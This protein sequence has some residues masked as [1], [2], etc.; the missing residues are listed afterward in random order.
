MCLTGAASV[1]KCA[2]EYRVLLKRKD[3]ICSSYCQNFIVDYALRAF[4]YAAP[5]RMYVT[6]FNPLRHS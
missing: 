3:S 5:F 2:A 1:K 4:E 6:V